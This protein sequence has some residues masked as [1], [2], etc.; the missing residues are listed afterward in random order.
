MSGSFVFVYL[1]AGLYVTNG[2]AIVK[3]SL[4][5]RIEARRSQVF[6]GS[7]GFA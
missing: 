5:A 4:A 6:N 1:C 2:Y 7:P 3:F